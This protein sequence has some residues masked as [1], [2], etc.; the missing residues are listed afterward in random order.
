MHNTKRGDV[1]Y[2]D[3]NPVIGSEQGGEIRPVVVIQNNVGNKYSPTLIIAPITNRQKA[4]IP[5]HVVLNKIDFLREDSIILLEQLKTID[6]TRLKN[7]IGRLD[8]LAMDI[9]DRALAISVGL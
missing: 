7:Y 4:K 3:L 8:D 5:T 9:V 6:R 2:A 1:Y